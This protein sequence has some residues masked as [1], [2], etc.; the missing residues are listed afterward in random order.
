MGTVYINH[1]IFL[2]KIIYDDLSFDI[3]YVF[4][5]GNEKKFL[6]AKASHN[7][8]IKGIGY[9]DEELND[10]VMSMMPNNP[11]VAKIISEITWK[12]IEGK[13]VVLPI[14]LV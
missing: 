11:L 13:E 1:N 4:D 5:I 7:N 12:Y 14:K 10:L 2:S 6:H 3:T 8:G 9:I